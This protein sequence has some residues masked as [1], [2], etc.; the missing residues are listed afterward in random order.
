MKGVVLSLFLAFSMSLFSQDSA[1]V[2]GNNQKIKELNSRL[3][4]LLLGKEQ[5]RD[6]LAI[7]LDTMLMLIKELRQEMKT[8]K[9][10]FAKIKKGEVKYEIEPQSTSVLE[11]G[12]FYVVVAARGNL[13]KAQ[14]AL[15]QYQKS[16]PLMIVQNERETWFHL[17][18]KQ[19]Y[20][21]NEVGNMVARERMNGIKD[22]WWISGEKLKMKD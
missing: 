19:S 3:D 9:Q 6:S 17:V 18:H 10:E 11:R 5:P 14:E 13:R 1:K 22:A 21:Q 20:S 8:I 15:L 2:E 12:S 16:Y 7:K 4:Q